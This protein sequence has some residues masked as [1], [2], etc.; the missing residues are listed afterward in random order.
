MKFILKNESALNQERDL[1]LKAY[2]LFLEYVETNPNSFS[3]KT[4]RDWQGGNGNNYCGFDERLAEAEQ[5]GGKKY[6]RHIVIAKTK[7]NEFCYKHGFEDSSII[8]KDWRSK[9]LLKSEKDRLVSNR[10]I[11]PTG[12]LIKCYVIKVEA[13]EEI[14]KPNIKK[15]VKTDGKTGNDDFL[16]H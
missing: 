2:D 12:N 14:P 7:F 10:K 6:D 3:Q 16:I 11:H 8:L 13:Q 4:H 5:V 15:Y 9:G 1:G